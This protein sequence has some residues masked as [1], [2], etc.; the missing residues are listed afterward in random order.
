[1]HPRANATANP[2][3]LAKQPHRTQ[4]SKH[5]AKRKST[6]PS[7]GPRYSSRPEVMRI[8]GDIAQRNSLDPQWVRHAIGRAHYM[9]AVALAMTPLPIGTPKN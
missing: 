1:M 8:A 2:E 9:P 3:K 4:A 7:Q 6:P 5:P